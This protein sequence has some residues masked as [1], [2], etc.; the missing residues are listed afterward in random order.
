MLF[1]EPDYAEI[2][3]QLVMLRRDQFPEGR[4]FFNRKEKAE[5]LDARTRRKN[6]E[7]AE[8]LVEFVASDLNPDTRQ[9]VRIVL[10]G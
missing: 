6:R 10:G 7:K 3:K 4:L 8:A 5:A 1:Q 2:W 9:Q